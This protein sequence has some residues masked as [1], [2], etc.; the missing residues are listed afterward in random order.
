MQ[1]LG[2]RLALIT[3]VALFAALLLS[4]SATA[5]EPVTILGG[6]GDEKDQSNQVQYLRQNT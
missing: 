2:L 3:V 5:E 6:P 4:V 1:T